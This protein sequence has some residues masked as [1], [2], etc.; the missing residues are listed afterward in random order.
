MDRDE[1]RQLI[2]DQ[3]V[4]WVRSVAGGSPS[5][6]GE[7]DFCPDVVLRGGLAGRVPRF[8]FVGPG[9]L[10]PAATVATAF[11]E[12]GPPVRLTSDKKSRRFVEQCSLRRVWLDCRDG[13]Q[14]PLP[15]ATSGS[16]SLVQTACRETRGF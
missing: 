15:T 9:C 11:H 16:T 1:S 10:I 5:R 13:S 3:I 6:P 2:R 12:A 4:R 7:L 8:A 14:I